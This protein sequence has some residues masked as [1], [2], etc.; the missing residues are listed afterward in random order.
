MESR[1]HFGSNSSSGR[2]LDDQAG[3]DG[4]FLGLADFHGAGGVAGGAA[5]GA[6]IGAFAGGVGAIPGA[7]VGGVVGGVTSFISNIFGW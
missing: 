4:L 3:A 2:Q 5:A 6:A 7:I 1:N